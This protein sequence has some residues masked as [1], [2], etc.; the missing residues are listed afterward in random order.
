MSD[1]EKLGASG[2]LWVC[3][4]FREP[5]VLRFAEGLWGDWLTS[6]HIWGAKHCPRDEVGF[7]VK[8]E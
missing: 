1:R 8:E 2:L 4:G 7:W 3:A 5:I 6:E